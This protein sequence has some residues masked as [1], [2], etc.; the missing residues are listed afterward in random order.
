MTIVWRYFHTSIFTYQRDG[1]EQSGLV[2]WTPSFLKV[3]ISK[4]SFFQDQDIFP[5]NRQKIIKKKF[6]APPPYGAAPLP[7]T[8]VGAKCLAA[9]VLDNQDR[10]LRQQ[11]NNKINFAMLEVL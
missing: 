11:N 10:A 6:A 3:C 1:P 5:K 4:N 2:T 9:V 8:N 7:P